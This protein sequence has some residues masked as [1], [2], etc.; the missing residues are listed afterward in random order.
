[1]TWILKLLGFAVVVGGP[2]NP[3]TSE[4]V[5]WLH[6]LFLLSIKC[7]LF[8]LCLLGYGS[9]VEMYCR[10]RAASV[11]HQLSCSH[12]R[13]TSASG[14]GHEPSACFPEVLLAGVTWFEL[15]VGYMVGRRLVHNQKTRDRGSWVV[16]YNTMYKIIW[17]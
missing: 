2:T 5:V 15:P 17:F 13:N 3:N 12:S 10:H 16:I 4:H 11:V 6:T 7:P 8:A 1:L 14:D 9:L